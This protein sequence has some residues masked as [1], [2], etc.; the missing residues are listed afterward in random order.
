MMQ[1]LK[2]EQKR[3]GLYKRKKSGNIKY[4]RMLCCKISKI[5]DIEFGKDKEKQ[6]RAIHE[7]EI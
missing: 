3:K 7:R 5:V 4:E 1:I 6:T 2:C